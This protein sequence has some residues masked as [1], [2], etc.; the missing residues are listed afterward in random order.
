MARNPI[1]SDTDVITHLHY[2]EVVM[3]TDHELKQ[4]ALANDRE[5]HLVFQSRLDDLEIARAVRQA[6]DQVPGNQIKVRV[7]HGIVALEGKVEWRWQKD[8][9]EHDIRGIHGVK[10]VENDI[11][12]PVTVRPI[13]VEESISK[14]LDRNGS[15]DACDISVE[16]EGSSVLLKGKVG[17]L[18][19]KRDTEAAAWSVAGVAKVENHLVVSHHGGCGLTA[20][21]TEDIERCLD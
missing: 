2:W 5:V 13:D 7:E 1:S 6:L 20:T 3:K 11:T 21:S 18:A 12:F 10:G 15:L 4:D 14:A 9:I 16:T 8:V 19:D 17:S